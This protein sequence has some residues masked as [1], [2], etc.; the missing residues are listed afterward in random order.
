MKKPISLLTVGVL[1]LSLL[2]GCGSNSAAT[3]EATA[4]EASAET[5][6][7][8]N[9]EEDIADIA[10]TESSETVSAGITY[11]YVYT[12]EADRE[13]TIE[14]EP[15][16]IV[17]NYL[18]LWES[19][20][21]LGVKPTAV[22]GAE[23]YIAT[24]DAFEGYDV[25]GVQ[26]LGTDGINLELL[27]ELQPDII[28]NQSADMGNL[29]IENLEKVAPVVVFGNA[30]KMDWRLSLREV[31]KV[32]NKEEKAEEVIAE[33]DAKLAEEREKLAAKYEGQTMIQFSVMGEDKYFAAYRPDLYDKE[34]GLGLNAPEGFT[35]SET[36]EQLSMEAI[37]QMNP[38]YIFVNV[39]DGDEA[40]L[41]ALEQ[42]SVWQSLKAVQDGHVYRLDGSGHAASALATLYTVNFITDAL[43]A[44]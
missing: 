37:V 43:T 13:V 5:T 7:V 32:V 27:A 35:T 22:T 26:D 42:N 39:F 11:P 28:L 21:L 40:L 25:T 34:T 44:E 4:T 36:Y 9:T 1:S 2:A 10:E 6:E 41:E 8:T 29:D 23:N 30:S 12:D 17:A 15:T 20:T 18:P 16:V 3:E 31:A 33:V 38:D 19:L 14:E 24:W